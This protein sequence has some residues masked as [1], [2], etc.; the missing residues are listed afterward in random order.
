MFT[1]AAP[2]LGKPGMFGIEMFG[3]EMLGIE[4]FGTEM[5]GMLML[6]TPMLGSDAPLGRPLTPGRPPPAPVKQTFHEPPSRC[7]GKVVVVVPPRWVLTRALTRARSPV[8]VVEP[9]E[10]EV[11]SPPRLSDPRVPAARSP[12]Q[13]CL[14][15]AAASL[16]FPRRAGR[17]RGRR[18]SRTTAA[19]EHPGREQD[20]HDDAGQHD[21]AGRPQQ[22]AVAAGPGPRAPGAVRTAAGPPEPEGCCP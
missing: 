22:A 16:F 4:M 9:I 21:D 19:A 8:R 3:T 1:P 20:E 11:T 10:Y 18:V 5:L 13:S 14:A 6:G 7:T 2:P 15:A 12:A 17:G